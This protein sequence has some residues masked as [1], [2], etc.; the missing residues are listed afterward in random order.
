M[1]LSR[2]QARFLQQNM[3]EVANT[4]AQQQA[5]ISTS[6][7]RTNL[8]ILSMSVIGVLLVF[9]T[10][11]MFSQLTRSISHSINSM[12]AINN[13]VVALRE[14][15]GL[16]EDSMQ[17]MGK[18]IEYLS[19]MNEH[20]AKIAGQTRQINSDI[21]VLHRVTAG[22]AT[23]TRALRANTQQI[24]QQF[25]RINHSF[26]RVSRSLHEVGKPVRQFFPLP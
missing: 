20:V 17:D 12:T 25:G 14:T 13:Q 24:D 2:E 11:L 5:T 21:S 22:I 26:G 8:V 9:L 3:Q 6:I 18:N 7:R 23:N 15:I 19:F 10:I 1:N 4:V 16:V